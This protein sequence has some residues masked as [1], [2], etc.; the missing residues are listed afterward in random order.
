MTGLESLE[1]RDF[2]DRQ[3]RHSVVWICPD[4]IDNEKKIRSIASQAL[5]GL[6]SSRVDECISFGGEFGFEVTGDLTQIISN[7][8]VDDVEMGVLD[9]SEELPKI[10]KNIQELREYLAFE[11]QHFS[12]PQEYEFLVVVT[13]NKAEQSLERFQIWR[14]LSNLVRSEN[15]KTLPK[16]EANQLGFIP[17]ALMITAVVIIIV[18]A[19]LILLSFLSR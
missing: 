14:S 16:S 2:R 1:K 5:Q 13:G 4:N 12:L 19:A 3:I 10:G 8:D 15:W 7:D 11:L 17:A 6:L 18:I 9:R